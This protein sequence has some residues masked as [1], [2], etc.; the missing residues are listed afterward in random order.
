MKLLTYQETKKP[1][2]KKK[3]TLRQQRYKL[4]RLKGMNQYN[5]AI[6]AGY[7]EKY[8]RQACRIERLVK[9][10]ISDII[11]RAG[12]TDKELIEYAQEGMKATK[13]FGKK[14][15][16]HADWNARHKFFQTIL[17]LKEK[18]K[19]KEVEGG[20]NI[21]PNI[22][23]VITDKKVKNDNNNAGTEKVGSLYPNESNPG[24]RL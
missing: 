17:L 10:S 6:A 18:L 24:N 1:R 9:V 4:N 12:L 2:P 5:A 19:S 16:E 23:V 21:S 13:L 22:T 3:F 15:I 7:S 14:G 11:E 8:A 20:I